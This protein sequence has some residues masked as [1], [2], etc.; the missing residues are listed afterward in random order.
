MLWYADILPVSAVC[1]IVAGVLVSSV[2]IRSLTIPTLYWLV[3][4]SAALVEAGLVGWLVL[5]GRLAQAGLVLVLLMVFRLAVKKHFGLGDVKFLA[6]A[7]VSYGF[8]GFFLVLLLAS[9]A[10]LLIG[11][12]KGLYR[13][14]I[15]FAPFMAFGLLVVLLLFDVFMAWLGLSWLLLA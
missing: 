2:D 11:L 13:T 4:L 12:L 5:F 8:I 6:A 9:L 1:F 15:A 10:G 7:T 14:K 3:P